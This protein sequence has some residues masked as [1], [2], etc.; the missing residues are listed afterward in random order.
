MFETL[1]NL[2]LLL[3]A[4]LPCI[5]ILKIMF[6]QM[7]PL[8]L[9]SF[10]F[11]VVIYVKNNNQCSIILPMAIISEHTRSHLFPSKSIAFKWGKGY[12]N[13]VSFF[14]PSM[15]CKDVGGLRKEKPFKTKMEFESL[16]QSQIPPRGMFP[17]TLLEFGT[18][19]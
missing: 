1:T 19:P 7:G 13:S 17:F 14:L 16:I 11:Q 12:C 10:P 6:V 15:H 9:T 2:F 3:P 4:D 8:I 18:G 5:L